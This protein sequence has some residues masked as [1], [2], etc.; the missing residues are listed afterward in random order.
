MN[1]SNFF[2][3]LLS[4]VLFL[5]IS[6]LAFG[7]GVTTSSMQGKILDANGEELIGANVV[8]IHQPS[9][10]LYGT[11]T[12]VGGNYRIPGMRV[13][14]PY[15]ITIS[16][17]GY[18][19]LNL[20]GTFLRLGETLKKDFEL[21]ESAIDLD[22]IQV[23]ASAGITGQN[24]GASSQITS[25]DIDVMPTL[26]RDI[27][28]YLRLTPQASAFGDGISFAG[29]NNRY[30]A[31]YI[32]GAVNNDVFGL[33][34]S[35]TNGGQTGIAPFSID[36][37]DQLQV[38]LSP[39]DVTLGGFAGGGINAVT[40]SGNNKFAG[41]AYYFFQN[42]GLAGE[43]NGTLA[44]RLDIEPAKLDEFVQ[45]TYGASLGGPI[46]KDKVFFF[47]NA[48][49]QDDETPAP[50]E[51]ENY[52]GNSSSADLDNLRNFLI[53]TYNYDPGTFGSTSDELQGLK[54]FGKIDINLNDK[55]RLTLRH[56]YT[57][58]EQFNR[59]P[60]N[61]ATLNFSNNGVFFP[62]TTNSSALELNS[63]FT[64]ALSNNLII[65]YTTVR[66]DRDPIGGDF[67]YVF[68]NDGAGTIRLGS[69]EFST[70]NAL[71]QDILSITD[72][73]K[74]YKGNHTITLGTHNEFYSIYNLFI[75][76]NYGTYR[77]A[78]LND[79]LN[80]S[81]AI[82][83]DRAYSLV[84]NITGD[85]SAAAAEFN[86]AQFGLYVQDE[87]AVNKQF[88][89]TAGLRVD[90]PVI[91][92]DPEEDTYFN[93]TALPLM[94]A[95]YDIAKDIEAGKAPDGQLMFSPRLGFDYDLTGDRRTVLRGGLG[96]FTSRIPFVWPGAMYNNNG[97]TLGRV[98]E[99]NISGGVA[100]E[101]DIQKQYT[102]PDFQIPSGQIDIFTR[103]FKYPQVFRT[104][105]AL[106]HTLP[107]GIKASLE[108]IYT[109]TLNNI[110]YTNINSDPTVGFNWTGSPDNRPVY[111]RTNID[112][113]YSAVYVGSNTSEG[114][115]YNVTASLAK[116]FTSGLSAF[117]A[118]T[119]G[120]AYAVNEGTSSQNSSQWRGQVSIDGRNFP[121]YGRS[122]YALGSRI[123]SAFSYKLKWNAAENAATTF[124]LFYNGQSGTA[125]SYVIGGNN[126][127]NINNETGST[128]ANRSLVYIP[129]N[130][131]DINLVDY[132][133][134][135]GN[136]VTAAQ[137]WN[138]LNA[139]IEDDNYLSANR[140]SYAEK[141]GGTAPFTSIFDFAIRQDF[142][143]NA[144]EST[145]RLQLSLDIFNLANLINPDW[146]VVYTVPGDFNN[147][148]L[149]QLE[150]YE[151]DG[152]TPRFTYRAGDAVGKDAFNI[153]GTAS[154]WRMRLG[155]RYIFN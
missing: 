91:T 46:V 146:G 100:F 14:G 87:W 15:N 95:N 8:A 148:F 50:F 33:A 111:T 5:A 140:G 24:A 45:T 13:G 29:V 64:D 26:N 89:L 104:N 129:A 130:A 62:S 7:Q 103:D 11:S 152:T 44:E 35:G 56:Q 9:G 120:D 22:V 139:F 28:D 61:N 145:H 137:Q 25:D 141:N 54:L 65:G 57:K 88:T 119:Y 98:D 126:G 143:V 38:V 76:Q 42:E 78:S 70:G 149:Y 122:D 60:G 49:I 154:R 27:D 30:N 48:E 36:I 124:S 85:G 74:L 153:A 75:G 94:Q 19:D 142:G 21:Q 59:N 102:H 18:A 101:P 72:N 112:P 150:G 73:L 58:A 68:I 43:T 113:T 108:G 39:Y 71:D 77:F 69:E 23:V 114:Y 110:V 6:T 127:R 16:Y 47:V 41:T 10:T 52:T 92:S 106:D 151:T 93:Q 116:D 40:K 136:T 118:Y 82:E 121:E 81:L 97:L 37:I 115:T 67:P 12:D 125:F 132:N 107:G 83:Y 84:D 99:R 138:N 90:L 31:I 34:S 66:D 134:S 86:A 17:T 79:F 80:D 55:N 53:N 133:D 20:E 32:D 128:S 4:L 96:I 2:K 123:V 131:S 135:D 109:K 51:I 117:L 144:G 105:L 3:P 63:R 147:Y 1:F 155:V